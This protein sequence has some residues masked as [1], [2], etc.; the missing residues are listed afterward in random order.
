MNY[1]KATSLLWLTTVAWGLG[2]VA[3]RIALVEGITVLEF[4][5]IR[6]GIGAV[7]INILFYKQLWKITTDEMKAG[8]IIGTALLLGFI[9]QTFGLL[10]VTP[11]VGGFVTATYVIIVPFLD[12][13]IY[14]KKI[15]IF[16]GS[17]AALMLVGL[18]FITISDGFNINI[19]VLPVFACAVF[20]AFQTSYTGVAVQKNDAI[21]LSIFMFNF[22]F[23][24][25]AVMAIGQNVATGHT[26]IVTMRAVYWLLFCG[27]FGTFMAFLFQNIAQ[28]HVN[29]TTAAVILSME[30]VFAFVFSVILYG[31][32]VTARILIGGGIILC[33]IML[34]QTKLSFLKR[35]KSS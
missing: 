19:F 23:V 2:F 10:H 8:A 7:L 3:T 16:E 25:A 33:A 9:A 12:R 22:V 4:I 13:F 17:A 21:R 31:E 11:S 18:G 14:K 1:N 35:L 28:K 24:C 27:V 34:C 30:S 15:D 32:I 29:A 20:Y 6:F 5:A 26:T